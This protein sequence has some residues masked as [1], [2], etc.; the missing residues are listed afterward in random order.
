MECNESVETVLER[1]EK[2]FPRWVAPALKC[3]KELFGLTSVNVN[4]IGRWL[5][6]FGFFR[7]SLKSLKLLRFADK[8]YLKYFDSG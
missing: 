8:L 4:M 5:H 2:Y 7:F 1:M 3:K 6:V